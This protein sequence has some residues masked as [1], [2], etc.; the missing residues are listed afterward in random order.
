MS[1]YAYKKEL[2]NDLADRM[3]EISPDEID[4]FLDELG[5]VVRRRATNQTKKHS[6]KEL[7]GLGKELWRSIDVEKYIEEER[8]SWDG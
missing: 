1:T 2:L 3:Q 6:V 7:R 4:Q 5:R 8:N